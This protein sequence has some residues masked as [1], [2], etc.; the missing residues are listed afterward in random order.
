MVILISDNIG[1]KAKV[2]KWEKIFHNNEDTLCQE[3]ILSWTF[4]L[5]IT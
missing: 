1:L 2:L 3:N 4:A 5:L